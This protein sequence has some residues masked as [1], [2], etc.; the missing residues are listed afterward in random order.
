MSVYI[1]GEWCK[2]DPEVHPPTDAA[3]LWTD[4][5]INTWA[6]FS[7]AADWAYACR[8]V[9]GLWV[10]HVC[11][12]PDW[13]SPPVPEPVEPEWSHDAGELGVFDY[14][15][16]YLSIGDDLLDEMSQCPRDAY[17]KAALDSHSAIGPLRDELAKVIEIAARRKRDADALRAAVVR[18][19]E[20]P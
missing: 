3:L 1:P 5:T 20:T 4:R 18:M 15:G 10:T 17:I 9:D 8:N 14:N 12:R 2:A 11:V 7:D 19:L 13:N 16:G 6:S